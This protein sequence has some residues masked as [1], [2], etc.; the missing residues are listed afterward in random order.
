M[1]E[2]LFGFSLGC[3]NPS[4]GS[5]KERALYEASVEMGYRSFSHLRTTGKEDLLLCQSRALD[6]LAE[7]Y[8]NEL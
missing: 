6:I 2:P 3:G 1:K 8:R 4:I 5:I 7:K